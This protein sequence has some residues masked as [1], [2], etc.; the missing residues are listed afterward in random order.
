MG[1]MTTFLVIM[2]GMTLLF[3]FAGLLQDCRADG[4]C[5]CETANCG[6]LALLTHPENIQTSD[7]WVKIILS[8]EGLALVGAV[9]FT[10]FV[11]RL[12]LAVVAPVAI[13]L[14]NILWD[15]L[16]VFT[17]VYEAA[18]VLA[19]LFFA[20]MLILFAVTILDW[21]RGND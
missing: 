19:I 3:Y 1:K 21:W 8:V 13:F 5:E 15:F 17:V 7:M 20:P 18:P 6:L 9:I 11:G 2:I 16:K 10:A 12:D 4:T 14:G